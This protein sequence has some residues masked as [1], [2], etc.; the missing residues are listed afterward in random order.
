MAVYFIRRGEDGPVKIGFAKDVVSRL[1]AIQISCAEPVSVIRLIEGGRE[2]E[3]AMHQKF[4]PV[5][6]RGEWHKFDAA[7]LNVGDEVPIPVPPRPALRA[8]NTMELK[9]AV[10]L[11]G[12][13]TDAARL[14]GIKRTVIHYW[15][16]NG[17]PAWRKPD[18]AKLISLAKSLPRPRKARSPQ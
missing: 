7:M 1:S 15:L 5:A 13:P 6:I 10:D 8:D 14:S 16:D 18:V 12:G 2:T 4:A 3:R 11:L 9:Q 17:A